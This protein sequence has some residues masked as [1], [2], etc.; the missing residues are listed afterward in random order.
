MCML[1]GE[2]PASSVPSARQGRRS[3]CVTEGTRSR[4]Q[5]ASPFSGG[6]LGALRL[7]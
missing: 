7:S 2:K 4:V 6:Q 3:A 5:L 1:G